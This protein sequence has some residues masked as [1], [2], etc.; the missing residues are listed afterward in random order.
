VQAISYGGGQNFYLD[1]KANAIKTQ[2]FTTA[3]SVANMQKDLEICTVMANRQKVAMHGAS[4]SKE[5]YD[6]ALQQGL[7]SQDFSATIKVVQ[8]RTQP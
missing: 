8:A 5:V 4:V 7:G 1:G 2:N 3:F 6:Q